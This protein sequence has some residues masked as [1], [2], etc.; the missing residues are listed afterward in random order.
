MISSKLVREL[1]RAIERNK[2]EFD[3]GDVVFS[4]A[5][6]RGGGVFETNLNNQGWELGPNML[7]E[8][9]RNLVLDIAYGAVAKV[10]AWYIAP[11]ADNVAITDDLTAANFADTQTEFTNYTQ[12]ARQVWT[13]AA[14]VDGV[15]TNAAAAASITIGATSQL[16]IYGLA[17]LSASPKL[18]E[19]GSIGAATLLPNPRLGLVTADILGLRYMIT[20]LST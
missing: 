11:F 2:F 20:L 5:K 3:G 14:A 13:P 6:L 19:N 1:R 12:P 7:P 10:A 4:G 17:M 9:S 8:Q 16:N 15:V 18:S